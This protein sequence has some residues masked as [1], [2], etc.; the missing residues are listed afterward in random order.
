MN[1]KYESAAF[2]TIV[3]IYLCLPSG[4]HIAGASSRYGLLPPK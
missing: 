1:G 4:V 3:K 2:L